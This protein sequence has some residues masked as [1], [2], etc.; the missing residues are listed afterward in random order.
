[1]T[2]IKLSDKDLKGITAMI[3]T[4]HPITAIK[5][6]RRMA[7]CDLK[8]AK[9]YVELLMHPGALTPEPSCH[10]AAQPEITITGNPSPKAAKAIV[11]MVKRLIKNGTIKSAGYVWKP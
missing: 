8:E 3:R 4:G 5:E 11:A 6:V 10:L 1:M 2:T 9:D 7:G